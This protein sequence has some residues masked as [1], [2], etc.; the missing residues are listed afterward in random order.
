MKIIPIARLQ[1][2]RI[3]ANSNLFLII[4]ITSRIRNNYNPIVNLLVIIFHHILQN[5]TEIEISSNFLVKKNKSSATVKVH[6]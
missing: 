5:R 6:L 2:P 1:R 4:I 3:K